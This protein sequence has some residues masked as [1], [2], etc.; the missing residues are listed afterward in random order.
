MSKVVRVNRGECISCGVCVDTVPAVFRFD[1]EGRAEAYAPEGA[2]AVSIQ[3]AV[4]LCPVACIY[5]DEEG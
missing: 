3:E 4:D 1:A 5:W 2:D